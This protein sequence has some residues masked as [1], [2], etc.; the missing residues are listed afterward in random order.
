MNRRPKRACALKRLLFPLT[1]LATLAAV[2]FL[3]QVTQGHEGH[4]AL[5]SKGVTVVGEELLISDG[6]ARALELTTAEVVSGEMRQVVKAHARVELPWHQQ[7][8]VSTLISGRITDVRVGPGEPVKAGDVL[9]ELESLEL[10]S[11]QLEL[12]QAQAEAKLAQDTFERRR[13]LARSGAIPEGDAKE[14]EAALA[15]ALARLSLAMCK[16]AA[17]A[18]ELKLDKDVLDQARTKRERLRKVVI[19]SPLNGIVAEASVRPGQVVKP[20]EYLFRIVDRSRAWLAAEVLEA[21]VGQLALGQEVRFE[22]KSVRGKVFTGAVHHL[23]SG[24]DPKTRTLEVVAVVEDK[25][26][27]LRPGM[28]GPIEFTIASGKK[29]LCPLQAVAERSGRAYVLLQQG[30]GKF[31]RQPVELG[32]RDRERVEVIKGLFPGHQVAVQ[33]SH[34]LFS[35]FGPDETSAQVGQ[36][37]K[38]SPSGRAST[39]SDTV[40]AHGIV[41]LPTDRKHFA[42][43]RISGRIA[44]IL[45]EHGQHVAAGA[46]LAEIESLELR[47]LQGELLSTQARLG[48]VSERVKRLESVGQTLGSRKELW[49]SQKEQQVL[50]SKQ[51]TLIHKLEM[52]G[53]SREKIDEL[54]RA[55]LSG[56]DC[57]ALFAAT[58][59]VVAPAEGWVAKFDLVPGQIVTAESSLFEISDPRK[60]WVKAVVVTNDIPYVAQGQTA[61]ISFLSRPSV[62]GKIV[63]V[64]PVLSSAQSVLPV[65]IEV[66]N[67]ERALLEGMTAQVE[68]E[69][70]REKLA[71]MGQR[72][73]SIR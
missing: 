62:A 15:Q 46:P 30:P 54:A 69:A 72:T 73:L 58:I 21:D 18:P 64:S 2:S 13:P 7:Q 11:L 71:A 65:W 42:S 22:V 57:Q 70:R 55:N 6:A 14:A 24:V 8:L 47:D 3:P 67:P 66:D 61:R 37:Q 34:V 4:A 27:I 48:W 1:G 43:S 53:L 49:E 17:A 68:I 25:Q 50:T 9:A 40:F 29:R 12:E 63:R 20:S 36:A 60:V 10:E 23:H 35:L 19:R 33:G 39:S 59:P 32:V 38:G 44:R 56:V 26:G 51:T 16:L 28:F 31:R 45:V 41:E 52:V 5:P